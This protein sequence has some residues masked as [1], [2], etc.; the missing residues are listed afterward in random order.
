M[1]H[2]DILIVGGGAAGISA[3]KAAHSANVLL[4]DRK[5]RL[6]GV[7]LQCTHRG[8]GKNKSGIEYAAELVCDFPE[9]VKLALGTTVLS[10]SKDK[11]ALLCG[12]EFGRK[13]VSFSRLILATGCREIPAGALPIAGT[14]PRG[15]YTAGQ[16]HISQSIQRHQ[17]RMLSTTW[18]IFSFSVFCVNRTSLPAKEANGLGAAFPV[19]SVSCCKISVPGFCSVTPSAVNTLSQNLKGLA[20]DTTIAGVW[21]PERC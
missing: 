5:P 1:E 4:V 11:T 9:N 17:L 3:A 14:R 18:V 13:E 2:Y 21:S 8:F 6:G 20:V 10:V 19:T 7:L 12:R 16:M 15:I